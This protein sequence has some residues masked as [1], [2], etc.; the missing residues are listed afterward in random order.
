MAS[1]LQFDIIYIKA[2]RQWQY[3]SLNIISRWNQ[4]TSV[5]EH[6]VKTKIARN[7][8][9]VSKATATPD[10]YVK[11][12]EEY[13]LIETTVIKSKNQVVLHF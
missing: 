11:E 4:S 12:T 2:L 5:Y 7:P 10:K 6:D 1:I 3:G 13:D 8:Y 9:Q